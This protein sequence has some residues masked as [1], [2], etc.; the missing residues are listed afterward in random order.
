MS[1]MYRILVSDSLGEAGIRRLA[2][3]SDVEY[4]QHTGL[5]APELEAMI[6]E[7]DALVV[8]SQT[9]VDASLLRAA[10]RLQVIG[11]AGAGT[12]NI[13][14]RTATANGVIV[15]NTPQANTIATAEQTMA[16]MLAASRHIAQAHASLRSGHWERSKFSGR[17]LYRKVLG[18]VGFGRVG[19]AVAKR[20]Q[21]FGMEVLVFDPYVSEE[22]AQEQGVTLQDLDEILPQCDYL[23]LHTSATPDTKGMINAQTIAQMKDGVI[24]VNAARGQLVDE[25]ALA[26]ALASGKVASAAIDVFCVEPP[27]PDSPLLKLPN[28]VHT[29][30]L[31]ASTLEAQRDVAIQIVDQVLDALRGTDFRNS[32]NMPFGVGPD[33]DAALPYMVLAERM[34]IL[35]FHMAPAP[36]RRVEVEVRGEPSDSLTRP[37]AA[38]LLKGILQ[39]FLVD[40]VNYVSAPVL[41][42]EH[43]ISISQSKGVSVV[44]Y[45]N[46][47]SCRVHWDGGSRVIAGVLFGGSHPRIVQVGRYHL[48]ADP[49]GT[50]LVM[51]NKDVPGVIGQVGTILGAYEVNIG[52]WRMGRN[53]PGEEALSFINLDCEPPKAALDAL[54]KVSAI[55][56]LKLVTL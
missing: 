50:L 42:E 14:V 21:A 22:V 10:K 8:R 56:K 29:P 13:D 1:T 37:V 39:G 3:A 6:G 43:G 32:I 12:D 7:Y 16:L 28:V 11:R 47:I 4:E 52:E 53:S 45:S 33:Y 38:A 25:E 24:L 18:L 15:M 20:A 46:L 27:S 34:G 35:Q 36:V 2:E 30:H 48:D 26:E 49:S 17:Q 41:A 9:Q 23:S 54:E 44:D 31:G 5:S 40:N 51:L 55:T 19:R